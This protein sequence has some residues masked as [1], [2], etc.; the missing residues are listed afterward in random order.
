[1]AYGGKKRYVLPCMCCLVNPLLE[2]QNVLSVPHR[3]Y[4]AYRVAQ[5]LVLVGACYGSRKELVLDLYEKDFIFQLTTCAW[6]LSTL[7]WLALLLVIRLLARPSLRNDPEYPWGQR[8][9]ETHFSEVQCA[10]RDRMIREDPTLCKQWLGHFRDLLSDFLLQLEQGQKADDDASVIDNMVSQLLILAHN[11]PSLPNATEGYN[12]AEQASREYAKELSSNFLPLLRGTPDCLLSML[13]ATAH[14]AARQ[15]RTSIFGVL[16]DN[17]VGPLVYAS[18]LR[19]VLTRY[20]AACDSGTVTAFRAELREEEDEDEHHVLCKDDHPMCNTRKIFGAGV[21]ERFSCDACS[22][23]S[24]AEWGCRQCDYDLCEECFAQVK[25]SQQEDRAAQQPDVSLEPVEAELNLAISFT[26]DMMKQLGST[27]A[28]TLIGRDRG[29]PLKEIM[30]FLQVQ[31]MCA[32]ADQRSNPKIQAGLALLIPLVRRQQGAPLNRMRWKEKVELF[33]ELLEKSDFKAVCHALPWFPPAVEV[34]HKASRLEAL[35]VLAKLLGRASKETESTADDL[36]V[37][38]KLVDYMTS[39]GTGSL[40]EQG[41]LATVVQASLKALQ[42]DTETVKREALLAY[43]LLLEEQEELTLGAERVRAPISVNSSASFLNFD[44]SSTASAD[45][46]QTRLEL[47]K[48]LRRVKAIAE[49]HKLAAQDPLAHKRG[50]EGEDAMGGCSSCKT[51]TKLQLA[52]DAYSKQGDALFE[53]IR[54][55]RAELKSQDW[56]NTAL[57]AQVLH[58]LWVWSSSETFVEDLAKSYDGLGL[59]EVVASAAGLA[60]QADPVDC[61]TILSQMFGFLAMAHSRDGFKQEAWKPM[62]E[63]IKGTVQPLYKLDETRELVLD[64]FLTCTS[65]SLEKREPAEHMAEMLKKMDLTAIYMQIPKV[66]LAAGGDLDMPRGLVKAVAGKHD[67]RPESSQPLPSL[68]DRCLPILAQS[69]KSVLEEL[70]GELRD[71]KARITDKDT[72]AGRLMD[73]IATKIAPLWKPL[74]SKDKL[75]FKLMYD[76]SGG[77]DGGRR[78]G[79]DS[80]LA[81]VMAM[82]RPVACVFYTS[83]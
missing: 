58:I 75:L 59:V 20:A 71:L 7:V 1:M 27:G 42:A 72:P 77:P 61:D 49:V 4:Y 26:N 6:A 22:A 31:E 32:G 55:S 16:A 64:L 63:G 39:L 74:E 8:L 69:P 54:G 21:A 9:N 34:K 43:H 11:T 15:G 25:V 73:T 14:V 37:T 79:E 19:G 65:E 17:K 28:K 82:S 24:G 48:Q 23:G 83:W 52:I 40:K 60:I 46:I 5:L 12:S 13:F 44:N 47:C 38:R 62:M 68:L 35:E 78:K 41:T 45:Q 67:W 36:V 3:P 2:E 50:E 66:K 81:D 33:K 10:V 70:A 57:A 53:I 29:C 56:D 51:G 18:Y 80:T 76:W 30:E